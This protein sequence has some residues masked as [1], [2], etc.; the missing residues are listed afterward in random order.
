[1]GKQRVGKIRGSLIWGL[2]LCLVLLWGCSRSGPPPM[3]QALAFRSRL[4]E[5]GGCSFLTEVTVDYGAHVYSF[6]LS[7][8]TDEGGAL[9]FTVTA[10]ESIAGIGGTVSGEQGTVSY[11]DTILAISPLAQGRLS[12]VAAPYALLHCWQTGYIATCGPEGT[13]TRFSVETLFLEEPI[14]TETWLDA[15]LGVPL[16]AEICYNDQRIVTLSLSEF[17]FTDH[18]DNVE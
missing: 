12:P 16:W 11:E 5:A 2:G 7:C 17:Q 1:M 6:T 14:S 9:A 8:R 4:L 3:E 18:S 13:T 10:P 15:E